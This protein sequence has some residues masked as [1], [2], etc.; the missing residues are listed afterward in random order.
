MRAIV[1][2][3]SRLTRRAG[4]FEFRDVVILFFGRARLFLFSRFSNT[5]P[6]AP[7]AFGIQPKRQQTSLESALT[8]S[9]PQFTFSSVHF[10]VSSSTYLLL[11]LLLLTLTTPSNTTF[12]SSNKLLPYFLFLQTADKVRIRRLVPFEATKS[13]RVTTPPGLPNKG[14]L[15]LQRVVGLRGSCVL[16]DIGP[17]VVS[18]T[19]TIP[20]VSFII[21]SLVI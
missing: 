8:F 15:Y 3:S 1:K 6:S 17:T 12:G 18:K 14:P 9:Y 4:R 13:V 16:S 11:L 7:S 19:I 20:L 5:P 10:F 2:L 21:N